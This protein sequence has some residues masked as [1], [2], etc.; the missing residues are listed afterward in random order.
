[1]RVRIIALG[2]HDGFY[3]SRFRSELI[4]STGEFFSKWIYL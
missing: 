4:N 2:K 3:D 1:M